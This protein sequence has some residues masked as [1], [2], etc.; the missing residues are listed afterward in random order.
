VRMPHDLLMDRVL[1]ELELPVAL[2][3]FQ[4]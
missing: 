2:L 1:A 3:Q 4:V